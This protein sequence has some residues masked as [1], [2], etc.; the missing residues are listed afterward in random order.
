MLLPKARQRKLGQAGVL[1]RSGVPRP[2]ENGKYNL[3][4]APCKRGIRATFAGFGLANALARMLF[5]T[6][7]R[8]VWGSFWFLP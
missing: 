5:A 2:S 1:S 3:V 7:L 4:W 8:I 6:F